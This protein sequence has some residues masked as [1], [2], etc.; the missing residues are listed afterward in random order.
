M[1]CLVSDSKDHG[2]TRC[3]KLA[4]YGIAGRLRAVIR[5]RLCFVCLDA[6]RKTRDSQKQKC[7]VCI[8]DAIMD[9]NEKNENYFI[10]TSSFTQY[11][12]IL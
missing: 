5:S 11:I 12:G 9:N 3:R 8:Y 1:R 2:S 10:K 7:Y 6:G 4:D